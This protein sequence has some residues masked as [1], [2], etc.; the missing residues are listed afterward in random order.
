[1]LFL[2]LLVG[3]SREGSANLNGIL[4]DLETPSSW[5]PTAETELFDRENLYDL[6]DGQAE[7][8]FAYGFEQ[9]AVQRYADDSGNQLDLELWQ[10]SSPADAFG[11]FTANI[12]G[13]PTA[14]GNDGDVDPGR[15]L[16]FWQDRYYVHLR[17][18]PALPEAELSRFAEAISQALP[19]GGSRPA[20]V[21][22]L[23]PAG[24]V[25][26]STLFFH[27]GISIQDRLWLGEE[28][29]LALGPKTD[30]VL[31]EYA[32]GDVSAQ[33]LLV[34][35]KDE[36]SAQDGLTTLQS[37]QVPIPPALVAARDDLLAA[38]FGSVDTAA[39]NALLEAALA[40]R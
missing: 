16:A 18:R 8:F 9:V 38:V 27:Q 13:T 21:E 19:G 5:T 2:L 28:N 17:A 33:L 10:T 31:A 7:A 20:L 6:V 22:R 36:Q 15:R 12:S 39:A 1:L 32:L 4:S 14:I 37:G 26:R 11:L 40:E 30:G 24:L 3:C 23:P 29:L 25:P 35:Y 34:Q